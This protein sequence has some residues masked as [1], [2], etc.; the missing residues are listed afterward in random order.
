[1]KT[2]RILGVLFASV[3]LS[4]CGTYS[5][6]SGHSAAQVGTDAALPLS[7]AQ[8]PITIPLPH[9]VHEP[10]LLRAKQIGNNFYLYSNGAWHG[11]QV[12]IYFMPRQNIWEDGT[13]YDIRSAKGIQQVAVATIQADG[14][15]RAVWN[16][17]G[18]VNRTPHQ[19]FFF[20]ARGNQSHELGL[21]QVNTPD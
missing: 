18:M 21:I 6:K 12:T 8:K 16:S 14:S 2:G 7:V 15:W 20:L 3:L 4:G 10:P 17:K 5:V 9:R 11:K 1:M 13:H 19:P